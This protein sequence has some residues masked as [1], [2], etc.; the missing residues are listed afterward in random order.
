MSLVNTIAGTEIHK[1]AHSERKKFWA[2]KYEAV[3]KL[4]FIIRKKNLKC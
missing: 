3:L 2:N 1:A 4:L